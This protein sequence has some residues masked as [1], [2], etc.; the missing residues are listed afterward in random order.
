[1]TEVGLV[2]LGAVL[3][4]AAALF[5]ERWKLVRSGRAAALLILRELQWHE[6]R[7]RLAIMAD[8]VPTSL[9]ELK[10]SSTVWSGQGPALIAGAKLQEAEAVL[11]WYGS[12][13][14]LGFLLARWQEPGGAKVTG[15]DRRELYDALNRARD[16]VER[17]AR[18]GIF[19]RRITL[20]QSLFGSPISEVDTPV[21]GDQNQSGKL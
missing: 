16:A 11:N 19:R 13:T 8:Q 17:I 18:T 7:L 12:M 5:I 1:V 3:S 21:E 4:L 20:T 6:D 15:P 10:F 14:V 2:L 9:Y